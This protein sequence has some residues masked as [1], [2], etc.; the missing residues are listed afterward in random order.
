[1][2]TLNFEVFVY[3]GLPGNTVV[4]ITTPLHQPMQHSA[5][6]ECG[7]NSIA[8]YRTRRL[9]T[10][11]VELSDVE[12][13]SFKPFVYYGFPGYTVVSITTRLRQPR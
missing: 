4:S 8:S 13:L 9:L 10:F 12:T 6:T 3:Y 2:E 1:M 5:V 7:V 11:I